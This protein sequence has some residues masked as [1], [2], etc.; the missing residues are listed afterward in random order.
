MQDIYTEPTPDEDEDEPMGETKLTKQ[1][2][3]NIFARLFRGYVF[4]NIGLFLLAI[5]ATIDM[6]SGGRNITIF[7]PLTSQLAPFLPS[8]ID[9]TPTSL[10]NAFLNITSILATT[11]I[12]IGIW[13]IRKGNNRAQGV[14][15]DKIKLTDLEGKEHDRIL[16]QQ[17]YITRGKQLLP[18]SMAVGIILSIG[19]IYLLAE[20]SLLFTTPLFN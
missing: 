5:T 20:T 4:T 10:F 2:Y 15:F 13:F 12:L 16:R 17:N 18:V 3:Q 1:G 11:S 19:L 8:F 9:I 14:N 7:A 6:L